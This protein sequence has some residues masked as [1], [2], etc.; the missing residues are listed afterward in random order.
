MAYPK[1]PSTPLTK[2]TK[3]SCAGRGR[4]SVRSRKRYNTLR[5][6]HSRPITRGPQPRV[7]QGCASSKSTSRRQKHWSSMLQ[8]W[9]TQANSIP[10]DARRHGKFVTKYRAATSCRPSACSVV[11]RTSHTWRRCGHL[12]HGA[13]SAVRHNWR[14]NQRQMGDIASCGY[15]EYDA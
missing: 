12:G 7:L 14:Q 10:A 5:A 1:V 3:A 4:R 2:A 8:G 11:W 9:R 13:S 15:T 6:K